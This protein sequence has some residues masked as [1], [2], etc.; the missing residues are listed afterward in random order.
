MSENL[1]ELVDGEWTCEGMPSIRRIGK[2]WVCEFAHGETP[3]A[4]IRNWR[5][6]ND[7]HIERQSAVI[8][9]VCANRDEIEEE[10]EKFKIELEKIKIERD[11]LKAERDKL[12]AERD[13][14]MTDLEDRLSRL[15]QQPARKW[16]FFA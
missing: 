15:E 1:Y 6:A 11:K 13:D 4:A 5:D 2:E 16:R 12:K 10:L 9:A 3:R 8:E 14:K 7:S